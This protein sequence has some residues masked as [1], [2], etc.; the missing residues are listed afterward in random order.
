MNETLDFDA[1][2]EL[3]ERR[4]RRTLEAVAESVV[5]DDAAATARPPIRSTRRVG[6]IAAVGAVSVAALVAVAWNARDEGE[7]VRIP[8]EA[9]I[10]RGTADG[11]DWWVIPSA[12]IGH[13]NPCGVPFPGVEIVS[14]DSN[15]PGLEWNTGG[16]NYGEPSGIVRYQCRG[17]E[18]DFDEL[19]W[20]SDPA[21]YDGLFTRLGDSDDPDSDWVTVLAVHPDV[22]QVEVQVDGGSPTVVPTVPLPSRPTGPRYAAATL[23]HDGCDVSIRLIDHGTPVTGGHAERNLCS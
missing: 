13:S 11:I 9:S 5:D 10:L 20:L 19:A 18:R 21:R 6:R 1:V 2:D 16:V 15:K 7:I 8:V 3:L 22:T 12:A 23:P 14:G 4:L 17:E